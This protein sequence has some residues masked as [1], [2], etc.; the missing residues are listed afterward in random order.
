MKRL[1]F[2]EIHDPKN[3]VSVILANSHSP[4]S[5]LNDFRDHLYSKKKQL[6]TGFLVVLS[7]VSLLYVARLL[8]YK[9]NER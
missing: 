5:A 4:I 8:S 3:L 9:M 2:I 7:N 1:L 6:S